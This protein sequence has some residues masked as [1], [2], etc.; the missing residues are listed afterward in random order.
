M[1]DSVVGCIWL[2]GGFSHLRIFWTVLINIPDRLA[3]PLRRQVANHRSAQY[4]KSGAV[5]GT[6][7]IRGLVLKWLVRSSV[8]IADLLVHKDLHID[9]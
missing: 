5:F 4:A 7:N 1:F 9:T 3:R 6:W 8:D 2:L